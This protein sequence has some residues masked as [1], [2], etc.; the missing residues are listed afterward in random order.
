MPDTSRKDPQFD[1]PPQDDARSGNVMEKIMEEKEAMRNVSE[2]YPSH[3]RAEGATKDDAQAP[4]IT[5]DTKGKLGRGPVTAV[6]LLAIVLAIFIV[7]GIRGRSSAEVVLAHN[8][9]NAA[10]E[11]VAV[12]TPGTGGQAQ[13]VKL[14][15]DTEGYIDT[16]IYARTNGYLQHWYPDI[17]TSV[18]KGDLL[19]V[20]QTPELDQQVEQAEE[21]VK[22]AQA[23]EQLAEITANRWKKLMAKDAVSQQETDQAMSDLTARQS[24]LNSAVANVRRL[25]Q[26]QGFEKIYAPF[27]GVITARN[28]DIGS[29][30]QA[31]DINTQRGELFHLSAIDRLRLYV[32]V[33]EVYAGLVRNGEH[34]TVTSDALPNVTFTGTVVRNSDAIAKTSRTL[35]VEVDVENASH[36]LLPGQYAFVHL[37]IPAGKTSMTLP[38]NTLLFRAEGLRVGVVQGGHVHLTPIQIGNDYGTSVEVTAGLQPTDK[39]ILNP[40]DSLADGA[41]VRIAGG[42]IQ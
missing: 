16:P 25:Q 22:T 19:A 28:V 27:D 7:L 11:P 18:R 1:V 34:L 40:A 36:R 24:T 35:N 3:D 29:L 21:E 2:S 8:T 23:N 6:S 9:S 32:P 17:G 20:V 39:V 26:I 31:G 42:Q 30:I 10:I 41:A 37:P 4:S 5:I 12:V 13:E 33:P 38:A 14:P 15:A